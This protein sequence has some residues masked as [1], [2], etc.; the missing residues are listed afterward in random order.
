MTIKTKAPARVPAVRQALKILRH[1]AKSPA[2]LGLSSISRE[3]GLSASTCLN[4]LR[5]LAEEDVVTFDPATKSY[6]LGLGLLEISSSLISSDDVVL[7]RPLLKRIALNY[8]ALVT[9]WRL[10]SNGR[11]LLIDREYGNSPVRIEM[12]L[13]TRVPIYSGALGRS[14]AAAT[15]PPIEELRRDF[16]ALRWQ[17]PLLFEEFMEDVKTATKDG[18][19]LDFGH[20]TRGVHAAGCVVLNASGIPTMAIGGLAIAGQL[21]V[22]EMHSL[23]GALRDAAQLI[24]RSL[25]STISASSK[26]DL[27]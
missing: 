6:Q 23:G 25:Y 7:I 5:T 21:S 16:D 22:E 27:R 24:E 4:Q 3:T 26:Q 9:L 15:N 20:W 10:S 17:S 11:L 13:G 19:G 8:H 1:L 2:P 12:R 14:V 18:F